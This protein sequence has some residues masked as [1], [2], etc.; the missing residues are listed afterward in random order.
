ML[1]RVFVLSLFLLSF[2]VLIYFDYSFNNL[3]AAIG[4]TTFDEVVE[5]A[6]EKK[7]LASTDPVVIQSP[8]PTITPLITKFPTI[9]IS[10]TVPNSPTATKSPTTTNSPITTKSPT[11][12]NSPTTT[13]SQIFTN[14][15]TSTKS[16]V[17][18]SAEK[19]S[20]LT[21]PPTKCKDTRP[22]FTRPL[23]ERWN[24]SSPVAMTEDYTLYTA[25]ELPINIDNYNVTFVNVGDWGKLCN[26]LGI[27]VGALRV[28]KQ[29][30]QMHN[31]I[32]V[33]PQFRPL[34]ALDLELLS[35]SVPGILMDCLS[36]GEEQFHLSVE[37]LVK[38]GRVSL[39][40][41]GG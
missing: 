2:I 30:N 23:T 10:R 17:T 38:S 14:S 16:S 32:A 31:F 24:C 35:K 3:A 19:I 41:V 39:H 40:F 9:T 25:E 36:C 33:R 4:E 28:M 7:F 21:Y 20:N 18:E 29:N 12:T 37:G 1:L 26:K 8:S 5:I 15:P 27:F 13:K 22:L 11:T 34:W 6:Q